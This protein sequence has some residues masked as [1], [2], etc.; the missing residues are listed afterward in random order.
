[1][2]EIVHGKL[3]LIKCNRYQAVLI[4]LISFITDVSFQVVSIICLVLYYFFS[5][6][7][8]ALFIYTN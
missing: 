1:M 5:F 8:F 4:F 7:A 6:D 2:P 3:D